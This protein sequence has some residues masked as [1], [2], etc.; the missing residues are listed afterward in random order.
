M[1]SVAVSS[2]APRRQEHV[3]IPIVSANAL[4][5]HH[6]RSARVLDGPRALPLCR[7]V[8]FAMSVPMKV[9]SE[10]LGHSSERVTSEVYVHLQEEHRVE[11][12]DAMPRAVWS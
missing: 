3:L 4:P 2:F 5:T 12:A 8:L 6:C 1:S 10:T 9:I 7:L 11:A